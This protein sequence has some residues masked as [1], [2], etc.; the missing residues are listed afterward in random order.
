[1][2]CLKFNVFDLNVDENYLFPILGLFG[3]A[4]TYLG[5]N[6]LNLHYLLVEH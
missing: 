4:I 5:I 6:L 1:M 3:L 2:D